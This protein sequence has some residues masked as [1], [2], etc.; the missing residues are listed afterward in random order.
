MSS[1]NCVKNQVP[2]SLSLQSVGVRPAEYEPGLV[3]LTVRAGRGAAGAVPLRAE[4]RVV[5]GGEDIHKA[6]KAAVEECFGSGGSADEEPD[7]LGYWAVRMDNTLMVEKDRNKVAW[8]SN[9]LSEINLSFAFQF[10]LALF[11]HLTKDSWDVVSS[12]NLTPT[13]ETD[14]VSNKNL[15]FYL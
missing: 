15:S 12:C 5:H 14:Q 6:V 9:S 8:K 13:V 11:S 3:A 4:V 7:N 1:L 10:L 2:S